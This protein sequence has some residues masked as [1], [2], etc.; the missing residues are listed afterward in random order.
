[1]VDGHRRAIAI[2]GLEMLIRYLLAA[3]AAG[4]L[5]R[6]SGDACHAI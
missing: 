4:L 1:M 3:L 6:A 5:G 2:E